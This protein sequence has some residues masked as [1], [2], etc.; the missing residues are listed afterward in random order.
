M[1]IRATSIVREVPPRQRTPR[2]GGAYRDRA[3]FKTTPCPTWRHGSHVFAG[4][5]DHV[6]RA[7]MAAHGAQ[8]VGIKGKPP[9]YPERTSTTCKTC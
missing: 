7:R 6:V 9:P 8:R 5:V 1:A 4:A 2:P 3:R